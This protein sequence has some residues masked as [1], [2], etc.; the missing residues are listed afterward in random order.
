LAP[1]DALGAT[2]AFGEVGVDGGVD[3]AERRDS[4]VVC[5]GFQRASILAGDEYADDEDG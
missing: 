5:V 3:L 2:L 1:G 4:V